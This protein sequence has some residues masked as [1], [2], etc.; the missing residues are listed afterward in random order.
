MVTNVVCGRL[1][2]EAEELEED[3]NPSTSKVL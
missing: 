1:N 2:P 3:P